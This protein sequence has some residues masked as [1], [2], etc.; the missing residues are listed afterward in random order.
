MTAVK[1]KYRVPSMGEVRSV[2]PNGLTCIS[3]FSG[4]GGSSL[5]Y[6]M[7][8][9]NVI[10]ANEFVEAARATYKAN[11]GATIVDGSD[12]RELQPSGVMSTLGLKAGEL[13]L[14]DGSPPCCAFSMAGSRE[15]LWGRVSEYSETAQRTDDL[16]FQ[17]IRFVREL[18][19]KCFIAENVKGLVVGKAKG[20]FKSIFQA[21]ESCGYRVG[22][23]V[24]DAQW[25]GVPQRRQRLIFF[26]VRKDLGTDPVFP[27]PL[28]YRY[29][30]HDAICD[31]HGQPEPETD[32]SP[33]CTG[34]E[35]NRL[36]IGEQSDK[37]FS[38]V[39]PNPGNPCPTITAT[40]CATPSSAGVA[41][42]YECRKWSIAELKRLSSFPDDFELV[43][44]FEQQ[45]ERIGRAVPPMMMY[46]I[47]R[48]VSGVLSQ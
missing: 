35:W 42:P 24:L 15:K 16:F 26:G 6:R 34:R 4:C 2:A 46:H 12:I 22:A 10:W 1:P 3:T 7:A 48:T 28:G 33:Y 18:Q 41:H 37:Y 47:A 8:G 30:I 45:A 19:P 23:R 32:L 38:L 44:T 20:Y 27:K 11:C 40:S 39:R 31:L 43:G 29:S 25:L 36:G 14:L 17:Y 13:D 9:F 5:G 21:L